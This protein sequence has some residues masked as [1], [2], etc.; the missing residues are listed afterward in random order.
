MASKDELILAAATARSRAYAPYSAFRVGCALEA[1]DG[2]VFLGCNVENVS[3]PATV[4]A[5]RVALGTGVA[6]GRRE[7]LRLVLLTD[8]PAPVA[9]CGVCRQALAEF[10]PDLEIVSRGAEGGEASWSLAELLPAPFGFESAAAAAR[11]G[12]AKGRGC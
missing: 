5:E 3:F 12:E 11:G 1:R 2:A 8:A 10:S 4:C 9:P 7:F 6:A